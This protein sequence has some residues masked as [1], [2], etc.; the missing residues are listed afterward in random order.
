MLIVPE[1]VRTAPAPDAE[2]ADRLQRCLAQFGMRGQ[3][4]VVVG[5]QVDHLFA[6][7]ARFRRARRFQN[8]QPLVGA[9]GAP[10]FQLIVKIRERIRH[11]SPGRTGFGLSILTSL[12]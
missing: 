2:F 5:G 4:Q 9:L 1:I 6:V 12:R 7:E 10:L 8:A 3:P 11:V